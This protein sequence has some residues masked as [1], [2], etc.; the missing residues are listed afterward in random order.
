[1]KSAKFLFTGIALAAVIVVALS[2]GIAR[3]APACD[4]AYVTISEGEISIS[5]TGVDDTANIQCAFDEAVAAGPGTIVRLLPGDFYTGQIVVYD[6]HGSLTGA[7]LT[8]TTIFNLPD[9]YVAPGDYYLEAPSADNPYPI[10]FAFV[11]GDFTI[12]D[13]GIRIVGET[14]AQEWTIYGLG[15][16]YDL[17]CAVAILGTD[18]HVEISH[19][20]VEGEVHEASLFGYNLF[21]GI[22]YEGWNEWMG[23]P[24][25]P[26]SGSF[27][28][29]DSMFRTLGYGTPIL[30]LS[31]AVVAIS[32]NLYKDL[33]CAMDGTDLVDSSYT[34]SHNKVEGVFFGLDFWD[35]IL[36]GH[37]GT[38]FLITNNQFRNAVYAVAFEQTFGEGNQCLLL[39][40]NVQNGNDIGILLGEAIY[41]CTVVGGSNKTNVLDLGTGNTLV[42]V[43]NMGTGVGPA[44]RRPMRPK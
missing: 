13:L 29:H 35:N 30:N 3:A 25:P 24:S 42:G 6:F 8:V 36:P 38:S 5:P 4:P 33:N 28:V 23:Q 40:N 2:V 32:R 10:L 20:L 19:V 18:A 39:G 27:S 11:D 17:A 34:F 7:G 15:P 44:I 14:P 26:L 9:L 16:I 21:N 43:N 37:T 22:Y 31:N 41:G 1:M 12:S